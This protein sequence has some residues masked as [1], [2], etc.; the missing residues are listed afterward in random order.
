MGAKPDNNQGAHRL[1]VLS[2][3]ANSAQKSVSVLIAFEDFLE[4]PVG[5]NSPERG[6]REA[7]HFCKNR[8][9]CRRPGGRARR[10][11]IA[12]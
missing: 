7:Q 10:E 1:I 4:I 2:D 8:R 5:E 3:L 9:R 6:T 11:T 12:K